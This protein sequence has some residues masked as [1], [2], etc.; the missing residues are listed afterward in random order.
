MTSLQ[1]FDCGAILVTELSRWRRSNQDLVKTLDD[2][3]TWKV[4]VLAQT[5][6]SFDL[7]TRERQAH[8]H[9]HGGPG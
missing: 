6:L 1:G 8:A 7:S 3:H 9:D 4:R 5:G 2:L